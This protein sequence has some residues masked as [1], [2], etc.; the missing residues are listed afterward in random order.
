MT[1]DLAHLEP[2]VRIPFRWKAFWAK[3]RVLARRQGL[4]SSVPSASFHL[5][6]WGL[7]QLSWATDAVLY[8]T[9]PLPSGLPNIFIVGHQRSGTTFLHRLL[10]KDPRAHSLAL[11]EMLLPASSIQGS[12]A[13]AKRLDRHCGGHVARWVS[14]IQ[15]QKLGDM[16]KIHR[17]RLDEPEEDEFVMWATF[18]SDM[19]INDN[20]VL[21]EAGDQGMPV[22]FH[23]WTHQDQMRSLCWYR[24]CVRKKMQRSGARGWYVGKN[25]RFARCLPQ[26]NQVFPDCKVILLV[27]NPIETIVSRMSFLRAVWRHRSA[28]FNELSRAHVDWILKD[29]IE[30]YFR[31]E[32]GRQD[33]PKD[34]LLVV[35]YRELKASPSHVVQRI[36]EQFNL[37]EPSDELK[38]ALQQLKNEP[39]RSKHDYNLQQFGLNEEEIRRPLARVFEHYQH[40]WR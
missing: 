11:H 29:S 36:T 6:L 3:Q 14:D 10:S 12:L 32:E 2:T 26:L 7:S 15:D 35:G 19:C 37:P 27:R 33:I 5:T 30:T 13:W 23:A 34:R 18:S 1:D 20:P 25:P 39:Y 9:K 8:P 31:T 22:P 28:G 17:V 21:I 40:L 16:D 38:T 24:A 4:L